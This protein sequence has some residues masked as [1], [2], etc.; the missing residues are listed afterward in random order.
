VY[1]RLLKKHS[2]L[3]LLLIL[4]TSTATPVAARSGVPITVENVELRPI[5]QSITLSGSVTSAQEAQ[6]STAISGLVDAVFVEE[7]AKI[8]T[9]D[10]LLTLDN[11]TANEQWK[12]A[13]A[14]AEQA[15]VSYLDASR[16]LQEAQSLTAKSSIAETAVRSLEAEVAAARAVQ[17]QTEAD[18][19]L[20]KALLERHTLKAPFSGIIKR[21]S[22][23]KG[24]WVV[25]GQGVFQLIAVD[26]LRLDFAVAEEY[27][28]RINA[29]TRVSFRAAANPEKLYQ[30][31]IGTLV[32]IST[33]GSRTF[34]LRI[35]I[36]NADQSII[37]GMSVQAQLQLATGREGLIVPRDATLRYPDGRLVVWSVQENADGLTAKEN[38]VIS[39]ETFGNDIEIREGLAVDSRVIVKGNEALQAGQQVYIQPAQE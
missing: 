28:S 30:A 10:L 11:E 18:A 20:Q 32:P 6:L 24:E 9:G 29:D 27:L 2:L 1:K 7:G 25:P 21:K 13:L 12:S 4:G 5:F 39:G 36:D 3:S 38:V 15:R 26:K 14:K 34:L 8:E 31:Q 35:P 19:R 33:P 17:Q 22:A 23:E 37:P 16:R